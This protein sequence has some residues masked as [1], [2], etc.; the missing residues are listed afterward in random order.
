MTDGRRARSVAAMT[1]T[2]LAPPAD[3]PRPDADSVAAKPYSLGHT[4]SEIER[5]DAQAASIAAATELLISRAGVGPGMRVLDLGTGL[6]HVAFQLAELVGPTGGVV[7]I[8]QAAALLEIAEQRRATARVQNLEFVEAD[9]RTFHDAAEFDAIVGRLILFHLQAPV[10][11]LRHHAAALRPG[12]LA[13][14][15]DFDVGTVRAEPPLPLVDMAADWVMRAFRHAGANPIVGSQLGLLLREAGLTGIHTF[16]TQAYLAPDDPHGSALLS[17][18]VN[19][20]APAIVSAGIATR[21]Q[22]GLDTL[23]E[24]LDDAIR[25]SGAVVLPP[26][27]VGAWGRV[28]DARSR[29]PSTPSTPINANQ[30]YS[31][32]HSEGESQR[33]RRQADELAS[34]SIELIDRAGLRPGHSAI[35]LG[36][37][38]R[39][40]IDLLAD[41]V[42]PG[43]RVL[44][45]DADAAMIAMASQFVADHGLDIVELIC[46]DARDTGLPSDTF[47]LVHARTLLCNVPQPEQVLEEMVRLARP[48]ACVA[49][50]EP[51]TEYVVCYPPD[52]AFQRL[53]EIFTLVFTRNGADPHIGRRVT[54]LY[55]QAG[56]QDVTVEVRAGVYPVGHSRRTIRADLVRAM[57]PQILS[58]GIADEQEL[59]RLD[60]AARRHLNDPNT[61]VMPSLN[62]LAWGRKPIGQ[63]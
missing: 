15:V 57:R 21:E 33:L 1:E 35:D 50:L 24:R 12:G 27:V 3:P 63:A 51:D 16:G 37:G 62:F 60:T 44:G 43:G 25:T 56:L 5:L 46:T 31:L 26:A 9:V 32:G 40:V 28:K 38:P 42:S 52:P 55:R 19:S 20:L 6:G 30:V 59:D 36:C 22:L 18:V 23:H 14:V 8:D 17:G 29:A 58:M 10:E 4:E 7:G 53:C 39:G 13:V 49:G 34:E 61:L 48:G 2:R 54:E 45:L 47:D 11:V 41:R